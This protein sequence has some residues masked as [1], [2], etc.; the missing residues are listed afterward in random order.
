[1]D[2]FVSGHALRLPDE[3]VYK[4]YVRLEG[5]LWKQPT[6]RKTPFE[7]II[8]DS[9]IGVYRL[10]GRKIDVIPVIFWGRNASA[11]S[12]YKGGTPLI[13]EGRWQ[14]RPY[15]KQYADGRTEELVAYELSIG[16]FK[17]VPC[18]AERRD[19]ATYA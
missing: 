16:T 12:T 15:T 2:C 6:F 5:L 17:R 13:A 10:H 3:L 11:V 18:S 19:A 9:S 14:S 8:S 4:N 7:R 1:M